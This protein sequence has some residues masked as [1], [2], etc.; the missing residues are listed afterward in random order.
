MIDMKEKCEFASH[1]ADRYP[2]LN[3]HRQV[4]LVFRERN[5][6]AW[7]CRPRERMTAFLSRVF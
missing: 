4:K 7:L 1:G 5:R 3:E 6:D 2:F